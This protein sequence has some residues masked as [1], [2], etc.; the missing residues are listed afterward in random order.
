MGISALKPGLRNI[1]NLQRNRRKTVEK[2]AKNISEFEKNIQESLFE[3]NLIF[4]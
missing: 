4:N 3:I 1:G 2:L